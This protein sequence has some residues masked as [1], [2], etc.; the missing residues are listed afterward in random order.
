[1]RSHTQSGT[2]GGSG[3]LERKVLIPSVNSPL[4]SQCYFVI[5]GCLLNVVCW[6]VLLNDDQVLFHVSEIFK[7][8][9]INIKKQIFNISGFL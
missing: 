8:I 4:T 9:I 2:C 6:G 1:M 7:K 3:E 5:T